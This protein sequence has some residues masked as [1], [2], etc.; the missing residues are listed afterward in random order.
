METQDALQP[1]IERVDQQLTPVLMYFPRL[2]KCRD[3]YVLYNLHYT[4]SVRY[5]LRTLFWYKHTYITFPPRAP[6]P[7]MFLPAV[8]IFRIEVKLLIFKN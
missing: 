3:S 5:Y 7:F 2:Y 1:L 6:S 8:S 4:P